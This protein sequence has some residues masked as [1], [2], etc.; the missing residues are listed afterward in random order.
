[1]SKIAQLRQLCTAEVD[2][3][4]DLDVLIPSVQFWRPYALPPLDGFTIAA[5]SFLKSSILSTLTT[6]STIACASLVAL[7]VDLGA[8]ALL[9]GR[10]EWVK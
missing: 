9:D 3:S 4:H 1:M 7:A 6:T 10:D 5:T 2:D 8:A